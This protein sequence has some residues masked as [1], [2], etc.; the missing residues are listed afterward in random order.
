MKQVYKPLPASISRRNSSPA[1][2]WATHGCLRFIISHCVPFPDP[3]GPVEAGLT[4]VFVMYVCRFV[5]M[6]GVTRILQIVTSLI[7]LCTWVRTELE[8]TQDEKDRYIFYW[9][10]CGICSLSLFRKIE[11]YARHEDLLLVWLL[12]RTTVRVWI[13]SLV[14]S[15]KSRGAAIPSQRS[16]NVNMPSKLM[17]Y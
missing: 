13:S 11:R 6:H 10:Q 1:E 16:T 9:F 17:Q 7:L 12:Q 15:Y 5:C 3:G 4:C 14:Y 8:H 2:M